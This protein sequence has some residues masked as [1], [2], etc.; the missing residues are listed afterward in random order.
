VTLPA[1]YYSESH[2]DD[3][4]VRL[5]AEGGWGNAERMEKLV[6][7]IQGSKASRYAMDEAA[8]HVEKA[9][10]AIGPFH[11]SVEKEAL[12][13]LARYILDRRL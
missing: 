5:L 13:E 3:P 8:E 1:I 9:L 4:E 12:E 10:E 6:R 7:A 11:A 2:P